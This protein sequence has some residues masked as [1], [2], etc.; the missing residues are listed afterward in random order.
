MKRFVKILFLLCISISVL[1]GCNYKTNS[2]LVRNNNLDSWI[3]EYE[4]GGVLE[5]DSNIRPNPVWVYNLDIY[6]ETGI[7][8]ATIEIDGYQ[9]IQRL[10]AIVKGDE[11][12]ISLIFELYLPDNQSE[13]YKENDILLSLEKKNSE[14]YTYWGKIN[15][16]VEENNESGKVYFVKQ[17]GEN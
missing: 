3:G 6:K 15:P 4:F 11:E 8:Y 16:I 14:I 5:T 12:F 17:T 2:R 13:P 10:K 7:Y 9:T 1:S